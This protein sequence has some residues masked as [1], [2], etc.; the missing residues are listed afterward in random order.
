MV[1]RHRSSSSMARGRGG[2]AMERSGFQVRP[3]IDSSE[4]FGSQVD[5]P[6]LISTV[7]RNQTQET[8]SLLCATPNI[9]LCT[10]CMQS[11]LF[12]YACALMIRDPRYNLNQHTQPS[13][14]LC[15]CYCTTMR[16]CLVLT[17]AVLVPAIRD[18]C[19]PMLLTP[20]INVTVLDSDPL[21]HRPTRLLSCYQ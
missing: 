1:S 19:Y 17:H 16:Q 20:A 14:T 7:T 13:I 9:A 15:T 2:D 11:Q 12:C 5:A 3:E 18:P 10:R 21:L 4:R 6:Y 8:A